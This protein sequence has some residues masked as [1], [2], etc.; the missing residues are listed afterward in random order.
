MIKTQLGGFE[1]GSTI[2]QIERSMRNRK[3]NILV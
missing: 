1:N 2:S 3:T